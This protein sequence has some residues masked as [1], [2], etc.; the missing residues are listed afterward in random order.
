LLRILLTKRK[1]NPLA[2]LSIV[3]KNAY[4]ENDS[5]MDQDFGMMNLSG[6]IVDSN[7]SWEDLD[8]INQLIE[9][10]KL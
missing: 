8:R 4:G 10:K 5:Y 1:I 7:C 3:V 9:Q 6:K 2:F